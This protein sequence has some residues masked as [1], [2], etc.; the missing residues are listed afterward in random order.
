[1]QMGFPEFLCRAALKATGGRMQDALDYLVD[2]GR[3]H[4]QEL[5]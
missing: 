5:D 1:M 3:R 2:S 4:R